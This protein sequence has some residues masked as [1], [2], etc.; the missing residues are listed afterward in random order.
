MLPSA[1]VA[2]DAIPL[3]HSGKIDRRALPDP[4]WRPVSAF[5]AARSATEAALASI[6]AKTLQVDRVG[7]HDDFFELG[8]HSLL[9][10]RL[11]VNVERELGLTIPL[12]AFF[13]G[14]ATVARMASALDSAAA[15]AEADSRT[16]AGQSPAT[17]TIVFF[18]QPGESAMLS[19]R[20][21]TPALGPGQRVV[22]L[23]PERNGAR[24]DQSRSIE[25]LAAGILR[26]IRETQPAGPYHLAGWSIGGLLAYEIASNLRA[27]GQD[28][29]WLAVLDAATPA[30]ARRAMHMRLSLRQRFARQR[31]RGLV[32]SLRHAGVAARREARAAL[33][34]LHLRRSR[35]ADDFDWRGA[36]T[37]TSRYACPGN[38]VPMDLFLS[39]E[40][41][42]ESGSRSLGWEEIHKGPLHIHGMPGTHVSM[43]TAPHMSVV[44][45][46]L[47]LRLRRAQQAGGAP[48]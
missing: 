10:V 42:A 27:S 25:D 2:V 39:A 15:G 4:D 7:I 21:F 11:L 44:A 12:A 19:L 30:V 23:L 28:V 35:F 14:S 26:T 3:T 20:H 38:D 9:A 5:G 43:V 48:A 47:T 13:E 17:T 31:E 18:V 41:V 34:R 46:T 24:F 45:E 22:G 32:G 6:W 36:L 1:Q 37:L 33:V 8:G 29:A 40:A 16:I